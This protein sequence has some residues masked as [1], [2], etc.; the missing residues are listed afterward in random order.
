MELLQ[1]LTALL[2][3]A[4]D[5]LD[6]S[7][8]MR[9]VASR[10]SGRRWNYVAF[11]FEV[12]KLSLEAWAGGWKAG[13]WSVWAGKETGTDMVVLENDCTLERCDVVLNASRMERIVVRY[14]DVLNGFP[15]WVAKLAAGVAPECVVVVSKRGSLSAV[16]GYR[17]R[18]GGITVTPCWTRGGYKTSADVAGTACTV[19]FADAEHLKEHVV[20][21]FGDVVLWRRG[22]DRIQ[23]SFDE[24]ALE[25]DDDDAGS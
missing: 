11:Q 17:G 13:S 23:R 9:G 8:M 25:S 24:L 1:R 2:G 19:Y 14:M 15:E 12:N 10:L 16:V 18:E 21:M 3:A 7:A 6:R 22:R 20:G 5:K 4:G